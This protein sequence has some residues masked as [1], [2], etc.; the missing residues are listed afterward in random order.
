MKNYAVRTLVLSLLVFGLG[1][2]SAS[3]AQKP[4]QASSASKAQPAAKASTATNPALPAKPTP[5]PEAVPR[6]L[7][8]PFPLAAIALDW[9]RREDPEM[10]AALRNYHAAIV[11]RD[12]AA[13]RESVL[14]AF[15]RI[16][17][18]ESSH[19]PLAAEYA[20]RRVPQMIRHLYP[21]PA[22]KTAAAP[23]SQLSQTYRAGDLVAPALLDSKAQWV[24]CS[25]PALQAAEAAPNARRGIAMLQVFINE[26]GAVTAVR[27][28]AGQHPDS[29]TQAATAE[30]LRWRATPPTWRGKPVKTALSVDIS[31]P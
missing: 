24:Q 16:A 10:T 31:V 2:E 4:R 30:L 8:E 22:V 17:L 3:A 21:C 11:A 6:P 15:E 27:P 25:E 18:S 20:T 12:R 23:A 28:R 13:L 14:P 7:E 9:H 5:Q 29:L 26:N 1:V 19:A